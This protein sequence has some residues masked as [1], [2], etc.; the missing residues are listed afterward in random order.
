MYFTYSCTFAQLHT[1][2]TYV[3]NCEQFLFKIQEKK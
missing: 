3:D 1:Y 2:N